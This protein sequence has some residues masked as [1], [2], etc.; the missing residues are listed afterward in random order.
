MSTTTDQS[1]SDRIAAIIDETRSI[2]HD[3]HA[4]P[5]I[6]FREERTA[7]VIRR[8]LEHLGIEHVSNVGGK[9]P[10]TGTGVVAHLPAT[11]EN[12]GP[13]IALRAD[14]DALPIQ[15]NS[16]LDYKSTRDGVMHACG[17]DG[18]TAVLLGTAHVLSKLEHRPNP[19]T[20][21]FQPAEE[22]GAGAAKLIRDGVLDGLIGPKVERI[23][24]LHGWPSDT[25]G[26]IS[27]KP[28]PLLASTDL[29][30]VTITGTQAH[31]AYPHLSADPVLA[32]SAII[33]GAQHIVSRNTD[34]NE[35]VVVSFT[36]FHAG[37]AINVIPGAAVL[38][39]TVRTLSDES[40]AKTK[41][42]LLELIEHTAKAH[43]CSAQIDWD[44]GYPVTRNDPTE[45]SRVLEIARS[46]EHCAQTKIVEH[47]T[48]GG[49]DFSFYLQ[50][51]PGCFYFMG[52][53]KDDQTPYPGLHTPSFNFNDQSLPLGVEMMCRLALTEEG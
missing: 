6:R 3:L 20:L 28:G 2:R 49:E 31:A 1:L 8:Q 18:H 5:E 27:T 33:Q 51:V 39:A 9:E 38:G 19:V 29:V 15:E 22:G 4:N 11:T 46:A 32:G 40:R 37:S 48:L 41:A 45:A 52:L 10:G 7:S 30:N 21:I 25:L 12:P 14:I 13:C 42:R 23:Y 24:G 53:A 47:A 16:D 34:P 43:G 26:T 35:A 36:T 50:K 17:H 44:P